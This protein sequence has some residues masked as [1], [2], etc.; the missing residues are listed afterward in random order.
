M[1]DI[2]TTTIETTART[3]GVQPYAINDIGRRGMGHI[4]VTAEGYWSSDPISIYVN[5]NW[6]WSKDDGDKHAWNITITHSSGGRD[7]NVVADD[8]D[9]AE[10]FAQALLLAVAEARKLHTLTDELEACFQARMA[11]EKAERERLEAEHADRIAKDEPMGEANA[12]AMCTI[13]KAQASVARGIDTVITC[14][15]RGTDERGNHG[16]IV[17]PP[18]AMGRP[19]IDGHAKSFKECIAHLATMS[20]RSFAVEPAPQE[21]SNV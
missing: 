19:R 16:S 14:I 21:E 4:A 15:A 1:T 7:T 13:A 18:G 5:R 8:A 12:K 2:N 6:M 17:F 9:A 10:N 11:E 20:H 3:Y